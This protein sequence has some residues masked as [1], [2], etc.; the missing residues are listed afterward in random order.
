MQLKVMS[1]D[2]E[3]NCRKKCHETN[4][5][6]LTDFIWNAIVKQPDDL[7]KNDSSIHIPYQKL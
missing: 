1:S 2:E 6:K 5:Q 3:Q 7:W 4:T